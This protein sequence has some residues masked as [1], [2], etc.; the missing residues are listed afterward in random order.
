MEPAC[1]RVG[2]LL[3]EHWDAVE[4]VAEALVKRTGLTGDEVR[5]VIRCQKAVQRSA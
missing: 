1:T 4:R 5:Q 2:R 3:C